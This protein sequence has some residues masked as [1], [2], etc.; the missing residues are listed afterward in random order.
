MKTP[1][2]QIALLHTALTGS[3]LDAAISGAVYQLKRPVESDK[4]DVVINSLPVSGE[5]LQR[6]VANVNIYVPDLKL[7]IG[8]KP[9][10]MPDMARLDALT[11]L[12]TPILEQR[13]RANNGGYVFR[14]ASTQLIEEVETQQ[15]YV[16]IRVDFQFFPD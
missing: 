4:E 13:Y 11:E 7:K 12:A 2:H 1:L 16:N 14:I 6:G 10:T 9:Q 8:G 5:Q 3:S 15:H